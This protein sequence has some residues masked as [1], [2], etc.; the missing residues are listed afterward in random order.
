MC[1]SAPSLVGGDGGRRAAAGL[2]SAPL[3]PMWLEGCHPSVFFLFPHLCQG[4]SWQHLNQ[5]QGWIGVI[6]LS[7]SLSLSLSC[8]GMVPPKQL[9]E[10]DSIVLLSCDIH[11]NFI[12]L[13]PWSIIYH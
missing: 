2:A 5:P 13:L 9:R 3:H 4:M 12:C 6:S 1:N 11:S 7:L 10:A 8:V